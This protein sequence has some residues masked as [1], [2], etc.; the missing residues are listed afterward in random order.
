MEVRMQVRYRTDTASW[1]CFRHAVKRSMLGEEIATDV[2][3]YSS[4]YYM[5]RTTCAD[6]DDEDSARRS[7]AREAAPSD[8]AGG[9]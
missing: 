5:G 4:D 9:T 1:L 6:C 7:R 8:A 2:D 3:D